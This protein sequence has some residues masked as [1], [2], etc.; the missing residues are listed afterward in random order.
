MLEVGKTYRTKAKKFYP[1]EADCQDTVMGVVPEFPHVVWTN[2]GRW[3]RQS[4][5]RAIIEI[6]DGEVLFFDRESWRDLDPQQE[7]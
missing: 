5:G 3:F 6:K 7:C 1:E 2:R 4:D